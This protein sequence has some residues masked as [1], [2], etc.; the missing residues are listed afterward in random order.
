MQ[1]C[2]FAANKMR[3]IFGSIRQVR[4]LFAEFGQAVA[5][6]GDDIA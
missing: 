6:K 5:G 4:H 3:A 1:S 2:F